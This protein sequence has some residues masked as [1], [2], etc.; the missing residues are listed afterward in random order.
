MHARSGV[1]CA[2]CHL[3][4]MRDGATQVFDPWVRSP[5]LNINH[6]CQTCHKQSEPEV[7]AAKQAGATP[8]QLNP[9][10]KLQRTAPWRLDFIAAENSMGFHAPQEAAKTLGEAID[11]ARQGELAVVRLGIAPAKVA[12]LIEPAPA[13]ASKP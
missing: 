7:E 9:A 1:A 5:L 11:C 3:L 10:L 8:E 12:A 13:P 6:A 4:C 2:D